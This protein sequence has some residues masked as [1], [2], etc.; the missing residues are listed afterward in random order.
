MRMAFLTAALASGFSAAA[1]A[2]LVVWVV[3]MV[4]GSADPWTA[5]PWLIVAATAIVTGTTYLA[6]V[7]VYGRAMRRRRSLGEPWAFRD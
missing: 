4:T 2:T 3:S 6:E 1:L 5:A 7:L